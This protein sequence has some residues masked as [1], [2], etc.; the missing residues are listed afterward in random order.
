MCAPFLT[1]WSREQLASS[2]SSSSSS[3]AIVLV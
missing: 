3:S 1:V 2:S